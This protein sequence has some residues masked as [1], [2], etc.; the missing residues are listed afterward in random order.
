[1]SLD[2][3]SA[4]GVFLGGFG[5]KSILLEFDNKI[6]NTSNQNTGFLITGALDTF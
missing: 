2:C 1:M 4:L 3:I 5:A 6:N